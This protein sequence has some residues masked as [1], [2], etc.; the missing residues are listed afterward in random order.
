MDLIGADRAIFLGAQ[1]WMADKLQSD[2]GKRARGVRKRC[3]VYAMRS[4]SFC[5]R[6]R[7]SGKT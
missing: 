1:L 5:F 3:V 4:S 6:L 7:Q 2:Q